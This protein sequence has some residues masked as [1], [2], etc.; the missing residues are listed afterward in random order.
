MAANDVYSLSLDS[1]YNGQNTVNVMHFKQVGADGTGDARN[2]LNIMF[3]ITL[4]TL[5]EPLFTDETTMVQT[6]A[7]RLFPTET[8]TLTGALGDPGTETS[9]GLP[10]QCC[11]ILRLVGNRGAGRGSGSLKLGQI[12]EGFVDEGRVDASYVALAQSLGNQLAQ[13]IVEG[14]FNWTWRCVIWN[15]GDNTFITV[16]AARPATRIRTVHSRQ[17]GVGQ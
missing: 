2:S 8:Q 10:P 4:R 11:A 15:P 13:D 9:N 7:R 14:T 16:Q 6:R 17:L 12:G 3:D 5:F 1:L